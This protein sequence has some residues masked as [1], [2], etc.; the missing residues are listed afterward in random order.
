MLDMSVCA[1][2]ISKRLCAD[3]PAGSKK[4]VEKVDEA[5]DRL[6]FLAAHLCR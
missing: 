2:I 6:V 5:A 1:I 4:L 3:G